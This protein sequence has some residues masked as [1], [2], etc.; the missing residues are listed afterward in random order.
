MDICE[1]QEG[2]V[3]RIKSVSGHADIKNA[4]GVLG[5][6][7]AISVPSTFPTYRY[8]VKFFTPI[9]CSCKTKCGNIYWGDR[10]KN[11]ELILVPTTSEQ[12]QTLCI[13]R[14]VLESVLDK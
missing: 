13:K 5:Q 3:V 6:I 2:D 8:R 4:I 9:E 7:V 14:K 12:L 1:L 10:F 11:Q